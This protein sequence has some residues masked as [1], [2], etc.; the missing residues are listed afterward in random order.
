MSNTIHAPL[1]WSYTYATRDS[2]GC[3]D[4]FISSEEDIRIEGEICHF[5]DSRND[6]EA[7]ASFICHAVNN[8]EALVA[9]LTKLERD[10]Y[11][12]IQEADRL[13]EMLFESGKSHKNPY[14]LSGNVVSMME[15]S[16]RARI[17]P[18]SLSG[19]K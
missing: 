1:P 14:P 19:G 4:F 17:H 6:K 13:G 10:A 15:S 18:T 16:Q 11:L 12:L 3:H 7:N 5:R 2:G 9:A 8:H